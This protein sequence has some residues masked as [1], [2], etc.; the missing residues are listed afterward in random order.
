MTTSLVTTRHATPDDVAAVVALHER[1][2]PATLR[3]RFHVPV[4]HVPERLVREL[5]APERGWSVL[6]EQHGEAVGLACAGALT[7]TQLE[8][9]LLVE[10]RLHGTGV[11]SG[12]LRDLAREAASRGYHSLKC[13][14]EPDNESMLPTVR[15]AGLHGEPSWVDGLVEIVMPLAVRRWDLSLPA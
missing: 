11:G 13:F 7:A 5:V 9:G 4:S 3:R 10:D 15:R 6:A 2:S 8:V 12:M 1:C 14:V